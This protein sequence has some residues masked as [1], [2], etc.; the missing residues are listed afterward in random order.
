MLIGF[1]FR[2]VVTSFALQRRSKMEFCESCAYKLHIC[3][4]HKIYKMK[5]DV[6]LMSNLSN[7][8]TFDYQNTPETYF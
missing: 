2:L 5:N 7:K 8:C 1:N 6:S 4:A 3:I